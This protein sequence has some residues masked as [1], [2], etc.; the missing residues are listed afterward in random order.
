MARKQ[1]IVVDGHEATIYFRSP[2]ARIIYFVSLRFSGIVLGHTIHIAR[3]YISHKTYLHEEQHLRQVFRYGKVGYVLRYLW[4][5]CLSGF[6]YR[7]HP[8]EREARGEP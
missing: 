7:N 1:R 8:M 3:S 6:S 2:L 5:W 4:L